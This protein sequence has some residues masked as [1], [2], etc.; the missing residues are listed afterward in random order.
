MTSA[1]L[2]TTAS[3]NSTICQDSNNNTAAT[4]MTAL[5]KDDQKKTRP[6]EKTL[7]VNKYFGVF[8]R[9]STYFNHTGVGF[10]CI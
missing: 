8:K 3:V 2:N 6:K 10:K 7:L 1:F 5:T 4:A 9:I